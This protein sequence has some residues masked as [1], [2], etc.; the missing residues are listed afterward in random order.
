MNNILEGVDTTG[1]VR[2]LMITRNIQQTEMANLLDVT[3][4]TIRNRFKRGDWHL[5]ELQVIAAK[6]NIEVSDLI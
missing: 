4:E 6:Y 3:E 5:K 1:K 2:A